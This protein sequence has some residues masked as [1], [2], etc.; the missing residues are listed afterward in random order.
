MREEGREV[1]ARILNWLTPR[2]SHSADGVARVAL[3]LLAL[4][5]IYMGYQASSGG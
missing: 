3:V 4:V 2:R 5:F 1:L